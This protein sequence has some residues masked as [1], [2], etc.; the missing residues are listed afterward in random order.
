MQKFLLFVFALVFAVPAPV[1]AAP[2]RLTNTLQPAVPP[3][4]SLNDTTRPIGG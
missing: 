4:S 3:A 2:I 1:Q